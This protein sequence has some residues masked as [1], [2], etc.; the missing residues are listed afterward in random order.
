M[1]SVSDI[2]NVRIPPSPLKIISKDVTL[3]TIQICLISV[4]S[5]QDI[6]GMLM[7]TRSELK[8]GGQGE[9]RFTLRHQRCYQTTS[10]L[11]DIGRK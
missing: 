2:N 1:W 8:K 3:I 4:I 7:H 6:S 11:S 10:L 9:K 5:F